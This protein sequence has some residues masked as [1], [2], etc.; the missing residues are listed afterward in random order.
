MTRQTLLVMA[1]GMALISG[2]FGGAALAMNTGGHG[3]SA[4]PGPSGGHGPETLPYD[5]RWNADQ[6]GLV[7][8]ARQRFIVKCE[9]GG[10]S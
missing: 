4:G 3:S 1:A 2:T 8:S 6:A 9:R 5:C 10:G 7:G